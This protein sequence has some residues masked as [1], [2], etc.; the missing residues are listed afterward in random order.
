[1][2]QSAGATPAALWN[3]KNLPAGAGQRANGAGR[4]PSAAELSRQLRCASGQFLPQ[5]R[6]TVALSLVAIGAMG[7]ISLY[8]MG[9]L[10]HLPSPPLPGLDSDRVDSSPEAYS[11]FSTPDG[12]LALGS[13]AATLAL[14]AM[15]GQDRARKQPWVPLALGAKVG[16]DVA[17]VLRMM[18]VQWRKYRAFCF[19]SLLA[20]A[21]TVATVPLAFGESRAA[22]SRLTRSRH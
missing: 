22:L 18:L 17:Q 1:M 9:L 11:R 14:A 21:A 6:A 20:A 4:K 3:L 8:Q 16:F 19:W 10:K 2:K 15:G 12:T 5:R 7:L 13:Y